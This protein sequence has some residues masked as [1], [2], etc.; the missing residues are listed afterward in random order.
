LNVIPI[1]IPPLRDHKSDISLLVNH[2]LNQFSKTKKK[3][4]VGISKDV[5]ERLMEYDWPGNVR[6]LENIIERM[7]ILTNYEMI[8]LEDLP[9]K[10]QTLSKMHPPSSLEIPEVGSHWILPLMNLKDN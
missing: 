4:I 6:E 8:S 7:V 9:E 10:I 3:K 2:F 1:E 5:M